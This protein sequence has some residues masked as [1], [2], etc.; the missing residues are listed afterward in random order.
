MKN[1]RKYGKAPFSIA[2]I[3]GGPGSAGEMVPVACGLSSGWGV[4]E[5]IQTATS[6]EGQVKELKTILEKNGDLPVTLVGFSWGAWLSFIVAADYP[7]IVKKLILVGSG[8]YEK[9]YAA[10][11]QD[12]RLSRLSEK[13][14]TEFE[15]IFRTLDDP[16]TEDKNAVFTRLGALAS[17]ADAYDPERNK[18][19]QIDCR[20]DIFQSVWADAAELRSSGKLMKL[21]NDIKCPVVAIHGDYDS[22][23]AEGVQKPL[24]A[25]LKSF[26]FILLKNCG[27]KPWIERWAKEDFFRILKDELA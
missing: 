19:E 12:I 10:R 13:E 20:A 1:L 27:H 22:H 7:E 3:H 26:R 15:S 17:K 18:S 6:L 16:A 23:P 9:K 11:I 14:R 2:V 5:P 4:L 25:I 8:P 21:G 24:S